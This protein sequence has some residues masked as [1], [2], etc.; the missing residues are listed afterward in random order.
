MSE[1]NLDAPV[2][3]HA[4]TMVVVN[5]A[6]TPSVQ[7]TLAYDPADPYAVTATFPTSG[8]PVV[9]TF[10]RDLLSR[11]LSGPVGDGDVRVW[12]S[13]DISGKAIV[14]IELTTSSGGLVAQARSRDINRFLSH[15]LFAVPAGTES[16]ASG[17]RPAHRP[18]PA[19][20]VRLTHELRNRTL[21]RIQHAPDACRIRAQGR[22]RSEMASVAE[23]RAS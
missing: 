4:I 1:R 12:P 20:Q 17:H 8:E 19:A 14:N 9:W 18:A 22:H 13:R 11:G 5:A 23:I 7:P 2:V 16:D 21:V 6:G 10:A 15:S 3:T